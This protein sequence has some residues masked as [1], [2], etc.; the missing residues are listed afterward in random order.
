MN[1][2]IHLHQSNHGETQSY[3]AE[4][5]IGSSCIRITLAKDKQDEP[6]KFPSSDPRRYGTL[7]HDVI[8]YVSW[9]VFDIAQNR[10]LFN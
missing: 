5:S 1:T 8:R 7:S 2:I 4:N 10:I 9:L 3:M 6:Y